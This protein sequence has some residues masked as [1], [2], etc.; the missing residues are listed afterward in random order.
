MNRQEWITNLKRIYIC[1]LGITLDRED[2]KELIDL[3]SGND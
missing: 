2:L 1:D 3:L